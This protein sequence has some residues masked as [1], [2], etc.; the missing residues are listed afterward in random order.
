MKRMVKPVFGQLRKCPWFK[1]LDLTWHFSRADRAQ[2][3]PGAHKVCAIRMHKT[4]AA[5]NQNFSKGSVSKCQNFVVYMCAPRGMKSLWSPQ[6]ASKRNAQDRYYLLKKGES[7]M[8]ICSTFV[9]YVEGWGV[10][11][12]SLSNKN[13]QDK[14]CLQ[15]KYNFLSKLCGSC[16]SEDQ[17]VDLPLSLHVLCNRLAQGKCCV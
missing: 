12:Q 10:S 2:S 15:G 1:C 3:P 6:G 5:C 9:V 4:S 11:S 16:E 8:F 13:A 14:C 17:L 7:E